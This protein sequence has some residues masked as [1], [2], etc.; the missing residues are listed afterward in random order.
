MAIWLSLP[1]SI[2]PELSAW[3]NNQEVDAWYE[4]ICRAFAH[5]VDLPVDTLLLPRILGMDAED[6]ASRAIKRVIDSLV[7]S[8]PLTIE[9][10]IDCRSSAA[11]GGSAPTYR[12]AAK[13]GLR[14]ALPFSITGQAGTEVAQA[15]LFLQHMPLGK[16]GAAIISAVQQVVPPDTRVHPE[17]LPLADGAAA[18]V[19]AQSPKML[20]K[21]FQILSVAIGQSANRQDATLRNVLGHAVKIAGIAKQDIQ[22]IITHR[23][24]GELEDSVQKTLPQSTLLAR[25]EHT[26]Y[27]FGC[28]DLLISLHKTA[29]EP[30][31]TGGIGALWFKGRFGTIAVVLLDFG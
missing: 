28:A 23:C 9:L 19:I 2:V 26:D 31:F 20:G 14:K 29:M 3:K 6:F 24:T 11:I 16:R 5:P 15:L 7:S 30:T 4:R 10:L 18:A 8:E 25:N 13:A 12:L 22:W 17:E 21:S 27:D 1:F